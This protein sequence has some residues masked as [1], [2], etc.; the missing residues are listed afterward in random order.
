MTV[1]YQGKVVN[2]SKANKAINQIILTSNWLP[3][4]IPPDVPTPNPAP[5]K[6]RSRPTT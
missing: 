5:T 3:S 1:T 6:P 2:A 4:V